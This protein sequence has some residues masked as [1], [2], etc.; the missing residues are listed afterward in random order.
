[1]TIIPIGPGDGGQIDPGRMLGA[2]VLAAT[3]LF[4]LCGRL[5][6]PYSRLA[7]IAAVAVY[8]AAF[9]GALV[10]AGLW[11]LRVGF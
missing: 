10:Y 8:G 1:M 3:A 7:R 11:L 5:P 6:A 4:L 9:L 2:L